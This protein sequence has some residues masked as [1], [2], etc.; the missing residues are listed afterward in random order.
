MNKLIG[1]CS[2]RDKK[3]ENMKIPLREREGRM[4][5]TGIHKIRFSLG[6][7]RKNKAKEY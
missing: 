2:K 6:S 1:Q 7:N 5:K 4:R 3:E